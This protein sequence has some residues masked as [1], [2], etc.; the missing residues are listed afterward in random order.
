MTGH[1]QQLKL[2]QTLHGYQIF[3][4]V[5]SAV[6]GSGVFSNNG[7][8]MAIAGPGG[9]LLSVLIMCL[10]SIAV[11][12]SIGELTQQFPVSNAIVTYV[13]ELVD[14]DFGWVVGL[15]YWYT[16]AASFAVQNAAAA[17]LAT[18]WGLS[19]TWQILAFYI[20]APVLLFCLNMTGVF[21]YGIVETIGGGLKLLFIIGVSIY[22]YVLSSE[23]IYDGFQNETPMFLNHVQAVCYA[24]PLV[25]Y[26][27]QGIEL[28]SITAFEARDDRAL[29]WPAR[30]TVY[31]VAFVYIMCT[32]GEALTVNWTDIHLSRIP[33]AQQVNPRDGDQQG[34][35]SSS[36]PVIASW[37]AGH[38][39][40]AGF[41]NGCLILSG[42][43]A[44]NTSLYASSRTLYGIVSSL[45]GRWWLKGK[46]EGLGGL[47]KRSRVP[48]AA[49]IF[50]GVAFCWVPFLR[51]TRIEVI[52]IMSISMSTSCL[53]VWAALCLAYL[54]VEKC[55]PSLSQQESRFVRG[56]SEYRSRMNFEAIQPLPAWLGLIGCTLIFCF[57]SAT[58]WASQVTFAK[59]ATAYAAHVVLFA[60]LISLKLAK[61]TLFKRWGVTLS[62]DKTQL[63]QILNS[64][65]SDMLEEQSSD[66]PVT[67]LTRSE[68]LRTVSLGQRE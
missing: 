57:S 61:G 29:R 27:F 33:G 53:I 67:S 24:I 32:V 50:S 25:A 39:N 16:Y 66:G 48:L 37:N 21:Y 1:T 26:S 35:A 17:E 11:S 55:G 54:R 5:L 18:Y 22:L 52:H 20:L 47:T 40:L 44:A 12:E 49:L 7:A 23:A 14:P 30:W 4:I 3:F 45:P 38:E 8:A 2:K 46:I 65:E 15:A 63:T 19:P 34:P 68:S 28:V 42:L 60:L 64:L 58:W 9:L 43:S 56:S 10:I 51:T 13:K 36:V 59:V 31:I 6:I 62:P 41:I